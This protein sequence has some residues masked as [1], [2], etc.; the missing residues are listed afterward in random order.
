MFRATVNYYVTEAKVAP[1]FFKPGT[2]VK[3]LRA[4]THGDRFLFRGKNEGDSKPI[5]QWLAVEDVE[6]KSEDK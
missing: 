2:Q 6:A 1:H 3:F 5:E 4:S